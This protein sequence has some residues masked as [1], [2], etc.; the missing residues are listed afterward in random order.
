MSSTEE[1]MDESWLNENSVA[2]ESGEVALFIRYL[3]V[4]SERRMPF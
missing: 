2:A 4:F 3:M 1:N